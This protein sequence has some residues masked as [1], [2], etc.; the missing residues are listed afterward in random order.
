VFFWAADI[1]QYLELRSRILAD[2]Y[3]R[4]AKEGIQLPAS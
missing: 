2:I 3:D 1:A 4:F